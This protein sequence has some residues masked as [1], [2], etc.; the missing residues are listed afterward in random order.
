MNA[1][2]GSSSPTEFGRVR[3]NSGTK[4]Y[5]YTILPT[6]LSLVVCLSGIFVLSTVHGQD[7]PNP[8][9]PIV[10]VHVTGTIS[11]VTEHF[12]ERSIAKAKRLRA[13]CIILEI[14]SPGGFL[15]SSFQLADVLQQI[16]WTRVV[17][18][19]PREALSG[20]AIASLGCKEIY[21]TENA[22][23]GDAGAIYLTEG[24]MFQHVPEKLR[25]DLALRV[26]QLAEYHS[27]PA[28]I[29]EAMV[30]SELKVFQYKN[31]QSG[32]TAYFSERE[33][34]GLPSRD[35]WEK[36]P[37]VAES[38]DGRFLEVSGKRAAELGLSNGTV[39]SRQELLDKLGVK[40]DVVE[41]RKGTLDYLVVILNHPL[42]TG[43]LFVVGLVA[44]Y[45]EL[46]S[47]GLGL[48]GLIAILSFSLFFW[49]RFLGGTA[50]WLEVMMFVAG[51][52][53]LLVELFLLPGFGVFGI[54]GLL[55]IASSLIL[56]GQEF[57]VPHTARQRETMAISIAVLVG[58]GIV[59]LICAAYL[60]RYLGSIAYLRN[61]VLPPPSS[62]P[63]PKDDAV[64]LEETIL[65]GTIGLSATPL[66][67][68]GKAMLAGSYVDVVTE[69]DFIDAGQPIEVVDVSGNR[70]VVR[71]ARNSKNTQQQ[72]PTA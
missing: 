64:S 4:I 48:G 43:L 7:L 18:F 72:S 16:A 3:A 15:T 27:R 70:I 8:S 38:G 21:L 32:E 37:A 14:D 51:I 50:G 20:A 53:L 1:G 52:V 47:P 33:W 71:P 46:A 22:R 26:R 24:G 44:L 65:K 34:A 49:S 12:V 66:R 9:G 40:G 60:T 35:L 11:P 13:Q 58:S 29:A 10:V 61:L 28:A 41:L 36:G 57:V 45:V 68:G 19:I 62:Q 6:L 5:G 63:S 55:L 25:S 30:D 17:V 69:G 42:I 67:P 54:T 31:S 2:S 23:F 59:F 39:G 56:A